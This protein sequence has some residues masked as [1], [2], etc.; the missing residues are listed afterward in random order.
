VAT[1]DSY[2]DP[3][4]KTSDDCALDLKTGA[5]KWWQQMTTGDA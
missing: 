5:I 3:P 2:S 1:G 4:A